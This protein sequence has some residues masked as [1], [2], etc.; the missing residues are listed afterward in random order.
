MGLSTVKTRPR[1]CILSRF[2]TVPTCDG[3]T[4]RRT[5]GRTDGRTETDLRELVQRSAQQAICR[6]M[7][8]RCKMHQIRFCLG[9]SPGLRWGSSQIYGQWHR[10]VL[11][12]IAQHS[13]L[14]AYDC[15]C[16]FSIFL[17]VCLSCLRHCLVNKQCVSAVLALHF[18]LVNSTKKNPATVIIYLQQAKAN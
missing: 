3:P 8:T 14:Q 1:H 11:P 10:A 15:S 18:I 6:P 12:K 17:F 2:D 9:L 4:D 13:C 16:S 5:D 7:L